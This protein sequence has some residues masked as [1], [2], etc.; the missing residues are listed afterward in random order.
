MKISQD[1]SMS[2]FD[3]YAILKEIKKLENSVID[4]IYQLDNIF[5]FK[6]R[7]RGNIHILLM[8]PEKRIHITSISYDWKLTNFIQMI[9]K[10][11]RGKR[12]SGIQQYMFDRIV[13]VSVGDDYKVI[14]EVIPRGNF[15]VTRKNK[16]LF[17]LRHIHMR[18]RSIYPGS[19]F[20]Y[21]PSSPKN[22]LEI[23]DKELIAY[24]RQQKT[25][26]RGL[27]KLGLG[28]KYAYEVSYRCGIDEPDKIKLTSYSDALIVDVISC[29]KTIFIDL[30]KKMIPHVY[31][32]EKKPYLFAPIELKFVK[33]KTEF[34]GKRFNTFS[35]ALDFYFSHIFTDELKKTPIITLQKEKEKLLKRIESQRKRI[36]ELENL[37]R[38]ANKMIEAIYNN[39]SLLESIL[40]IIRQA[41][42]EKNLSWDEIISKINDAKKRGD[43]LAQAIRDIKSDG[44]IYVELGNELIELNIRKNLHEIISEYYAAIKKNE[45]KMKVAQEELSK[46]L[47][48]LNELDITM[49]KQLEVEKMIIKNPPRRWYDKFYWFVSSDGFLILGGK[50]AQTNDMLVKKYMHENDLFLHAEIHGGAVVLIKNFLNRK[51]PQNTLHEAAIYAASYSK[52]WRLGLHT[53]DVFY[54]MPRDIS[55]TPPSGQY[56]P[57]GSFIIRK[58]EYIKNV[59]LI[60]SVGLV[61]N[62]AENTAFFQFFSAPP[63]VM[64]KLTKY[65]VLITPGN[66]KKSEVA[67]IILR[68]IKKRNSDPYLLRVINSIRIEKIVDLIPGPSNILEDEDDE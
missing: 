16:V 27:A 59:P 34:L 7:Q 47:V 55:L 6:L 64:R 43:K 62:K 33:E 28:P 68:K 56:L 11:L 54:T 3:I 2:S 52:A 29:L 49:N 21:P 5:G 17:A 41:K 15:I 53:I 31:F 58:K 9:R 44:T 14:L 61:I 24:V 51:I 1:L 37:I 39:Y 67:K 36:S 35:T 42:I 65:R 63:K 48:K 57:T 66:L 50:D 13:E 45:E 40:T 8:E 26:L 4:N 30:E 25:L 19:L 20:K 10:H 23:S 38:H 12:I 32:L 18:D 60:L 22:P 46:S